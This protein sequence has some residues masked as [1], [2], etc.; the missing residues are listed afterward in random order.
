[1]NFKRMIS[2]C[3]LLLAMAGLSV[4]VQAQSAV[5][6]VGSGSNVPTP[7]YSVWTDEFNK[8][9]SKVQ[10]RYLSMSTMEGIHQI[11]AGSGDFA[12]G[13][14]PLTHEQLESAK[15][16]LLQIPTVLVG[17]VPIYN[18]P[19]NPDVN[20]S[21]EVLA[22]I[23]MGTITNWKDPR[24]AKL[25]P[26]IKLPDL[27]IAVVHRTPGKGSNYI[28]TDFLS[29]DSPEFRSQ[30]GKSASPNWPVG[31]DANRGEDMV[32][33]VASIPGAVGYVELN[34][35]KRSDIGYG[36]VQN[37]AGAFVRA[38]PASITA[39]CKSL[40][41]TVPSDFRVSLVNAP[42]QDAYP[43][44][45]FTWIYLPTSNASTERS[46]A[47]KEFLE[48]SLR[49]GQTIARGLGYAVLPATIQSKA[50]AALNSMQ[51]ASRSN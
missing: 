15:V 14:I 10:V 12:A 35:A 4:S 45:S 37:P 19:G 1:M 47:L 26:T 33:K 49:D 36:S 23:F 51:L 13:E 7:L 48:W 25:N 31:V 27:Q 11:S 24:I 17:I 46:I 5:S 42:A 38:T 18:L 16:S 9:D 6:I 32:T 43:I 44:A 22:H 8:K 3:L 21:G 41:G 39:A 34:F 40:A 30:I 2:G 20:F 28:F 29:K 50:Q